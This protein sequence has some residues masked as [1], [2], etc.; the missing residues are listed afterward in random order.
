MYHVDFENFD[1]YKI[2]LQKKIKNFDTE[3]DALFK[4]RNKLI[5]Q[6]EAY[7]TAMD[8]FYDKMKDL[9]VIPDVLELY[10]KFID[11]ALNDYQEG[12]EE[13]K[14]SFDEILEKIKE[15]KRRR[16]EIVYE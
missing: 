12:V 5:W 9:Y 4:S 14:K 3:L 1:E 6:G 16:G 13:I 8:I 2:E 11:T 7:D 15:E 10:V